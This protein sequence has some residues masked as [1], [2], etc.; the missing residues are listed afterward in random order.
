MCHYEKVRVAL[1][2]CK[3]EGFLAFSYPDASQHASRFNTRHLCICY[4]LV[5]YYE[6]QLLR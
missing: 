3:L 4:I 2:T 6:V 1:T 5:A